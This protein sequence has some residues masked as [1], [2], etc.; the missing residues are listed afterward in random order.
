MN[1]LRLVRWHM[2]APD[3]QQALVALLTRVSQPAAGAQLPALETPEQRY[4]AE[5]AALDGGSVIPL[6][7]VPE[8]YA[9]G[10]NVRDWMA[11]KWGGWRLEDVWLDLTPKGEQAN[12]GNDRP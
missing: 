2:E 9:L 3:S 12:G 8:I 10:P 5:R 4:A 1:D 11:P 6:A 7:F